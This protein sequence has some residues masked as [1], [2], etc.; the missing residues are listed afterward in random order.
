MTLLRTPLDDI[1]DLAENLLRE[2]TLASTGMRYARRNN[3]GRVKEVSAGTPEHLDGVTWY[4]RALVDR[5]DS[6]LQ[7]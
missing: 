7:R 6:V 2:A 5:A 4:L 3:K 1:R